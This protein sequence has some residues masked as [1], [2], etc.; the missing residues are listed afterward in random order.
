MSGSN[1]N[2]NNS[3]PKGYGSLIRRIFSCGSDLRHEANQSLTYSPPAS[4]KPEVKE[5]SIA[6]GAKAKNGDETAKKTKRKSNR[7]I[8]R[9]SAFSEQNGT[10]NHIEKPKKL[11]KAR[12]DNGSSKRKLKQRAVRVDSSS[13]S[14][15]GL[16]TTKQRTKKQVKR[17]RSSAGD[18]VPVPFGTVPRKRTTEKKLGS[19][20]KDPISSSLNLLPTT[21]R[22]HVQ[23]TSRSV[24]LESVTKEGVP[25]SWNPS[26]KRLKSL[27]PKVESKE[28]L[29]IGVE[30]WDDF[31]QNFWTD[32]SQDR[33]RTKDK[34]V[35]K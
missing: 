7:D 35:S 1:S 20:S 28:S 10:S 21:E 17:S 16:R 3:K 34:S 29:Y 18:L 22:S 25:I 27:P 8:K 33:R 9:S 24:K 11:D 6:S 26:Q 15:S 31:K 4:P 5:K 2:D 19:R 13:S 32:I 12:A 14:D 23:N 30:D